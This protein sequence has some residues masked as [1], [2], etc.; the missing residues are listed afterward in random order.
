MAGALALILFSIAF[1]AWYLRRQRPLL[2]TALAFL[3]FFG[4]ILVDIQPNGGIGVDLLSV[5]LQILFLLLFFAALLVRM[6]K[7]PEP[8]P[9]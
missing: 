9:T 3:V 2:L 6:R 7:S 5:S 4:V 8:E 1:Y